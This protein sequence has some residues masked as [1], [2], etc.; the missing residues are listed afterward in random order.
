MI[1]IANKFLAASNHKMNQLATA[2]K[3][4]L[5]L[6]FTQGLA[7]AKHNEVKVTVESKLEDDE[8]AA[9]DHLHKLERRAIPSSEVLDERLNYV[10]F[11]TM[12]HVE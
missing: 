1:S 11:R 2:L 7:L 12:Q 10:R 6:L 9:G 3:I 4:I 8:A 5:A